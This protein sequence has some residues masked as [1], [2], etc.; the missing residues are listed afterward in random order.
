MADTKIEL[1]LQGINELMKSAEVQA[2]LQEEGQKILAR[3]NSLKQA[4]GAQYGM[5]TKAINWIAV[6]TVRADNGEA[7]LD[8][9]QNNT[10]LKARG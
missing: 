2:V 10:L 4:A 7:V 1:N 5:S 9:L 3:A 8:N 6:T